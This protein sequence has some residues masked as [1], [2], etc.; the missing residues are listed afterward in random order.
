MRAIWDIQ[1]DR[2]PRF[3]LKAS[4]KHMPFLGPTTALSTIWMCAGKDMLDLKFIRTHME[5]VREM[6][7]NRRN[8]LDLS[9][10]EN[11]DRKRRE[12]LPVVEE[13]RHRRNNVSEEIA[14]MKEN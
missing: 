2:F 14:L 11:I 13:L 8:D 9:A 12:I 7:R 10:F 4:L 5:M 6:L 3:V 1:I